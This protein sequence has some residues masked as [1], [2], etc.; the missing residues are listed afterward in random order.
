MH[1]VGHGIWTLTKNNT[2]KYKTLYKVSHM[3]HAW[4]RDS[5]YLYHTI[6]VTLTNNWI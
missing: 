6:S 3:H 4:Y 2:V 1:N 5:G